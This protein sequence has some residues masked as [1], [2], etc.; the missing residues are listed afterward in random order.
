MASIQG[1]FG[2]HEQALR[3]RGE[4]ASVLAANL[5]NADTPHYKARDLDFRQVLADAGQG[6]GRLA[7]ATTRP[8]HLGAPGSQPG[9]GEL[10]YRVPF[11]PS[12]DGNTVEGP[13][14][15]AAFG[16]NAVRYQASLMFINRRIAGLEL[17]MTGR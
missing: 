16:E 9:G 5:A 17:A 10:L 2:I 15:L 8:G 7:V 3:L 1:F 6:G 4:R 11:Q 13:V 12:L 14:E